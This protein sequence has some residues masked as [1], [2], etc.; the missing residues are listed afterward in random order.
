M[1][2]AATAGAASAPLIQNVDAAG[3]PK[4]SF[5]LAL[6]PD[7]VENPGDVP[8][9][10]V[11]E[12]GVKIRDVNVRS[13]ER[14]RTAI[15]AVLLVDTSGSMA[16]GPLDNAKLAAKRFI[17]SMGADDR[18]A[19]VAFSDS[20]VVVQ[21]YT[22]D[23][24]AL[25]LAIDQLAPSGE[26]SLYDGLVAAASLSARSGAEERYIVALSDGGDTVSISNADA[27]AS[28][29]VAAETP[30]YAIALTSP[31]YTPSTLEAIARLANGRVTT[32][33]GSESL[34][35]IYEGIA[36]EMQARYEV[37]FESAKPNTMELTLDVTVG[38]NDG[39]AVTTVVVANPKFEAAPVDPAEP[40]MPTPANDG[41]LITFTAAT[42]LAVLLLILGVGFIL[43][44]DRAAL[45][46]LEYYG[47]VELGRETGGDTFE[48]RTVRGR[49][50]AAMV[51]AVDR[52]GFTGKVQLLLER[53]GINLRANEF[54]SFVMLIMGTAGIIVWVVTGQL[55]FGIIAAA[56]CAVAPI[57]FLRFMVGR[58]LKKFES[59]LPDILDMLGSSLR[60]GWGIQQALDLVVEEVEQ[61]AKGE[62]RRT[63]A[64]SRLGMPFEEALQRMTTRVESPD[65]EWVVSSIAIQREVGGN[66]AEVL[67][68]VSG[69]IR[70]RG[71]LER[72]VQSLTAEGRLT[73]W[74]L[75]G[76]PFVVFGALMILSPDFIAP[77]LGSPIGIIGF[78]VI[79]LLLVIGITMLQKIIKIKV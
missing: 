68:I 3:Y 47:Q 21:D 57:M 17:E 59:Q 35:D 24:V 76:L 30:I 43:F 39:A 48:D 79:I 61:P 50:A 4:I 12:N 13:L 15:D 38:S 56:V 42:F 22:T 36:E 72:L 9:V 69:T 78:G 27:A 18:I 34:A 63:Q 2:V 53:G 41:L 55:F 46:Q 28:A 51:E 14:Q 29:L 66:L 16:G 23:R 64:E 54:V 6:P 74:V 77:A 44:R 49:L 8:E 37:E 11:S 70:Q 32:A 7:A 71:E 45:E 67:A 5:T 75:A 31:E 19:L 62:F 10:S 65:L 60:S 40:F 26:T 25:G 1:A 33:S 52:Q 73:M 20:P 58:R